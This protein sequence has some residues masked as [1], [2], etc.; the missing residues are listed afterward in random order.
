MVVADLGGKRTGST[1]LS[2]YVEGRV[3]LPNVTETDQIIQAYIAAQASK[4]LN[5]LRTLANS[6]FKVEDDIP[7]PVSG[8]GTSIQHLLTS[9]LCCMGGSKPSNRAPPSKLEFSVRGQAK[10]K[11]RGRGRGR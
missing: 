2:F 1:L 6:F 3:T 5:P 7:T 9:L 11:G 4:D 10:G 8:F